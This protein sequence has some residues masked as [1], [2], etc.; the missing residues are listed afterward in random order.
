L[1]VAFAQAGLLLSAV[2]LCLVSLQSYTTGRFL[3]ESC[4]RAQALEEYSFKGSLPTS[5]RLLIEAHKFELPVLT[6]I[7]LGEEWARFFS[8][9]T[10]FDLYGITWTFCVVFAGILSKDLPI[11]ADHDDT[12]NYRVYVGIFLSIAIPLSCV[13]ILDQ[14][15]VQ[16]TFLALRMLM[17]GLMLVTLV[18]LGSPSSR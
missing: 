3:L 2:V 13:S 11:L 14:V 9:T 10:A 5:Q 8:F 7:F 6:R 4:A 1:S 17:V 15:Y 12:T 18:Y 16:L